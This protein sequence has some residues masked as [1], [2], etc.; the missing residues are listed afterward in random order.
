MSQIG[1][2][3]FDRVGCNICHVRNIAT[4]PAGTPLNGG[5]F[6]VSAALGDK[7]IHPFSDFLL[8]DLETG[9]GIV[10][11]GGDST[12]NKLRTPP[13][14]GVRTRSRLMHD[15]ASMTFREAILRH[16]GEAEQVIR[17]FRFLSNKEEQQLLAFLSSL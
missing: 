10:Q 3:L 8:H 15:G 11:N 1:S 12:R 2:T 14:W 6:V 16:E 13:L 4:A 7:I 9:D 5:T 17:R